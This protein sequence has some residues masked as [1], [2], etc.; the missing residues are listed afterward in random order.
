LC[1]G[2]AR[3]VKA[4]NCFSLQHLLI[5][6]LDHCMISVAYRGSCRAL[7]DLIQASCFMVDSVQ[8]KNGA[9]L[10]APFFSNQFRQTTGR[11]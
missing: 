10:D 11:R 5:R 9:S 1:I 7:P 3:L 8:K 4:Y 6:G 2:F